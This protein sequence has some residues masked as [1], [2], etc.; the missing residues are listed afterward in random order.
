LRPHLRFKSAGG[1]AQL[2]LHVMGPYR[3]RSGLQGMV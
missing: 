3:C 1:S 2:I